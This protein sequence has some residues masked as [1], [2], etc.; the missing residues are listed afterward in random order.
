MRFMLL[1]N[2]FII[3]S[4]FAAIE[5]GYKAYDSTFD[6][7]WSGFRLYV[8]NRKKYGPIYLA[9]QFDQKLIKVYE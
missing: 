4:P 2:Q 9:E 6:F 3:R 5:V 7:V 8:R 1:P